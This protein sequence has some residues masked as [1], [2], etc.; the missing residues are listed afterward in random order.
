[1]IEASD[2]SAPLL[3]LFLAYH[4]VTTVHDCLHISETFINTFDELRIQRRKELKMDR[5][6]VGAFL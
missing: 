4:I 3:P 1:M 5:E 2:A 6:F